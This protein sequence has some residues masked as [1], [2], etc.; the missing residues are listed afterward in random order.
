MVIN[1]KIRKKEKDK[2][3]L[4]RKERLAEEEIAIN[5]YYRKKAENQS[6]EEN[7]KQWLN[8]FTLIAIAILIVVL[9]IKELFY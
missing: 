5:E 8:F 2:K 9:F 1:K 7:V 4:E 6:P 3:K